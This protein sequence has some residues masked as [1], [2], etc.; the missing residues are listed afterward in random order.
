MSNR[1]LLICAF[2]CLLVTLWTNTASAQSLTSGDVSGVI[3][4]PSGAAIPNA[5]VTLKNNATG[6][7]QTHT[8]NGQGSYRFS[9]LSPG[10]YSISV[11]A[12]SF[13]VTQQTVSVTVGQTTTL[14]VQVQLSSANVSV[15][16][17]AGGEVVQTDTADMTTS[18][19][20][21]QI[22][23]VPNPGNDLS[24]IVQTSPGA[25]MN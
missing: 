14:N 1:Y 6:A 7:S 9:L 10:E 21:E 5:A 4:D 20:A 16:V 15:D 3:T 19:S 2:T 17:S 8:T 12:P 24:Y 13:Q 25:V 23:Q 22:A 11:S 18:F